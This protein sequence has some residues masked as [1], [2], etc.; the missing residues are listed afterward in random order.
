MSRAIITASAYK[1]CPVAG[2]WTQKKKEKVT[3][4][5]PGE[6]GI[7]SHGKNDSQ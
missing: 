5:L 2:R 1:T 4:H 7:R 6:H 3:L